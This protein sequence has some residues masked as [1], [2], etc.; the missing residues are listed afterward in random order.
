[1]TSHDVLLPN[2]T[3]SENEMANPNKTAAAARRKMGG[4]PQRPPRPHSDF[5]VWVFAQA[6]AGRSFKSEAEARAAF[7]AESCD[8]S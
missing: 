1:M 6:I 2:T 5:M 3:S 4:F 7:D 8:E